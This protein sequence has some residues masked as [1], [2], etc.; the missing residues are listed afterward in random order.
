MLEV[1]KE[2]FFYRVDRGLDPSGRPLSF[3]P[4][5]TFN[6]IDKL[7]FNKN[8]D[9]KSRY[10]RDSGDNKVIACWV[11]S[12]VMPC[13]VRLGTIRRSDFPQVEQ[14]GEITALEMAE[15]SGLLEQTHI[16]FFGDDIA[17]SDYNFF[18]P[19]ITRLA[20]Y[21]A[22]KAVGIAPP[23]LN[24]SPI[25]RTD[26]YKQLL[27][28]KFL[29]MFNIKLKAP[30]SGFIRNLDE[31]IWQMLEIAK[32]IGEADNIEL[33]LTASKKSHGLLSERVLEFTKKLLKMPELQ[34]DVKK[35]TVKGYSSKKQEN[36]ILDLLSDRFVVKKSILKMDSRSRALNSDAAYR[37]IIS[38]Y[39]ELKDEIIES[40]SI[41]L[42]R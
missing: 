22:D 30:Q 38:A 40:A 17:A 42:W 29:K 4:I 6:H 12:K 21:L 10:W 24:F 28:L 15:G 35:L 25:L 27:E 34:R 9:P 1:E 16:V 39:K 2:I 32:N 20:Y 5:P 26:I 23:I 7:S 33:I 31:S 36:V 11:D 8:V 14:G 13:K 41:G 37:A 18:G 3:D 19:R